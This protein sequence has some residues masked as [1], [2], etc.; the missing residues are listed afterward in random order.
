MS[1]A[2]IA[3]AVIT[4]PIGLVKNN[5]PT[6]TNVDPKKRI[7]VDSVDKG[8]VAKPIAAEPRELN[9]LPNK[10]FLMGK[11]PTDSPK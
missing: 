11:L 3:I 10:P 2:A 9:V 6:K 7:A 8:D 5:R 4:N 1:N